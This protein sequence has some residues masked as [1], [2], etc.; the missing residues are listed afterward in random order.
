[1]NTAD[2]LERAADLIEPKGAWMQG[3]LRRFHD[4]RPI[5]WCAVGAIYHVAK[6]PDEALTVRGALGAL[7]DQS[8]PEW[9]DAPGRTQAE[10]VAKLREAAA[11]ARA[12]S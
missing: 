2:I 10:V 9:N 3:G 12:A 4:D 11:L 5:C 7:L 1:M 8:V 6:T